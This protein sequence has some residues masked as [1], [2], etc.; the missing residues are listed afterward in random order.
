MKAAIVSIG[1]RPETTAASPP[2]LETMR[3][4]RFPVSK[5]FKSA[6]MKQFGLIFLISPMTERPNCLM[7]GVPASKMTWS[8][9][10]TLVKTRSTC[11][12]STKSIA[13]CRYGGFQSLCTLNPIT[14]CAALSF[15]FKT[16]A[17]S[18][19][20]SSARESARRVAP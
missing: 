15:S 13:T 9:C 2:A 17:A 12:M 16:V 18:G 1:A 6:T 5:V 4:S 11:F 3:A 10:G 19:N 14:P 7:S 20:L 8:F